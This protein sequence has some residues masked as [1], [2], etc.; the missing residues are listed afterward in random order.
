MHEVEAHVIRRRSRTAAFLSDPLCT[1]DHLVAW[2]QRRRADLASELG[3]SESDPQLHHGGGCAH[4]LF[5]SAAGA[6]C[7]ADTQDLALE[8]ASFVGLDAAT[9]GGKS[10]R[11]GGAT[12]IAALLGEAG[13]ARL[14]K[15]G[16]WSTDVALI[17]ERALAEP[18]LS[19][20]ASLGDAAGRDLEGI[21]GGWAQPA[22]FR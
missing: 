6:W 3:C 11:A 1:Y 15:R 14:K 5:V 10:F 20:S 2:L 13:K 17:Y 9:F 19:L 8:L 12:D 22:T 7:T 21:L 18:D 4:P 16:R